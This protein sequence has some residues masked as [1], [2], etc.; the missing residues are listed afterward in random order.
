MDA[1]INIIVF[2]LPS[3]KDDY[4]KSTVELSK[5]FSLHEKVNSVLYVDYQYT[6]KD[7]ITKFKE[8]NILKILG[9]KPRITKVENV[10]VY[11][12]I[13]ILPINWI[14]NKKIFNIL[15]KFN[16]FLLKIGIKKQIKKLKLNNIVIINALNP[17]YGFHLNK[18]INEKLTVY[19]C[20]DEISACNWIN[21]HGS[22]YEQKFI[23]KCDLVITASKPLE[24]EKKKYN[25]NTIVI[26]NGV[27]FKKYEKY[28]DLNRFKLIQ[29]PIVCYSGAIDNR[30]DLELLKYTIN[31]IQT[32]IFKFIGPIKNKIIFETLSKY[33]NVIF[34]GNLNQI[35]YIKELNTCHVGIIP[36]VKNKFTENSNVLKIYDYFAAGLQIVSTDFSDL[37]DFKDEIYITNNKKIFKD[38]IK[39]AIIHKNYVKAQQKVNIAEQHS[40]SNRANKFINEI[41]NKIH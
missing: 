25:K 13:P 12:P 6:L 36:F 9:F 2:G 39:S 7:I 19:Y 37:S 18:K 1:K 30:I 5:E 14:K 24:K 10:N 22:Y 34:V 8:L 27:P 21:I 4:I 15:S 40:W 17:I 26:Q 38:N 28:L 23:K 35:D 32:A 29:T 20:Y 31:G 41:Y 33:K 3:W 16:A 11:S